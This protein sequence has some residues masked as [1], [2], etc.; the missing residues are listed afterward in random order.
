MQALRP[1]VAEEDGRV[2]GY[3]DL[4]AS[5]YIDHFFVSGKHHGAAWDV[6]S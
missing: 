2:V 3:A 6:F 5:G 4:Q 1:L